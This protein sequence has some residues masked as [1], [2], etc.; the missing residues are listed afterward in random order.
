MCTMGS[1]VGILV[2]RSHLPIPINPQI[3]SLTSQS[4]GEN[5]GHILNF[6]IVMWRPPNKVIFVGKPCEERSTAK[7]AFSLINGCALWRLGHHKLRNTVCDGI[8]KGGARIEGC[9]REQ[10][11]NVENGIRGVDAFAVI[12]Y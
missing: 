1:G 5:M 3:Q 6:C 12:S 8:G 9:E 7:S 11:G 2:W 10:S 4:H